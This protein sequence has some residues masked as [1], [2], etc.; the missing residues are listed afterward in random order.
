MDT[1]ETSSEEFRDSQEEPSSYEQ[2]IAG[3]LRPAGFWIRLCAILVDDAIFAP[4]IILSYLNNISIKSLPLL[5]ALYIPGLIYKPFMESFCGATLGKMVC[6]IRVMDK[7]GK[8]LNLSA[9]YVR[10]VTFLFARVVAFA[11]TAIAFT[12]PEYERVSSLSEMLEFPNSLESVTVV[13]GVILLCDCGVVA[14]TRSKC[15]VHDLIAG[16]YCVHK[17]SRLK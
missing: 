10:Y 11:T 15:A 8:R 6:G 12:L 7:N 14:F 3:K 16:S 5:I 4:I 9:A 1:P 13:A 2:D 17:E